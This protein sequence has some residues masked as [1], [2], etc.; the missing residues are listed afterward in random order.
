M[1]QIGKFWMNPLAI[2]AVVD[3]AACESIR[4]DFSDGGNIVLTGEDRAELLN[5]LKQHTV[6]YPRLVDSPEDEPPL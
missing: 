5:Y 4:V 2:T 3:Q 1:W 6:H